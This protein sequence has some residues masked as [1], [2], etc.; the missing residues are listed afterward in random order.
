MSSLL[1]SP[2]D[3]LHG[4]I[5]VSTGTVGLLWDNF[6]LEANSDFFSGTGSSLNAS[7]DTVTVKIIAKK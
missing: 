4:R 1:D 6:G 2:F 3:P 5:D 7:A